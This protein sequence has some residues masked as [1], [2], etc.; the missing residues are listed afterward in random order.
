[1]VAWQAWQAEMV[2]E[3]VG[4]GKRVEQATLVV[5]VGGTGA[6]TVVV[7]ALEMAWEGVAATGWVAVG[8]AGV[9]KEEEATEKVDVAVGLAVAVALWAR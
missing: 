2:S 8:Q 3:V 5:E 1:M 7:M 6:A 9:G 4:A